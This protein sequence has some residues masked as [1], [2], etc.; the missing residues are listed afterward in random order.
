MGTA[1]TQR[2]LVMILDDDFG[3]RSSLS[4]LLEHE[5]FEV[6]AESDGAHGLDLLCSLADVSKVLPAAI[7]LDL[8]MPNLD[9][10]GFLALRRARR[11]DLDQVP[12]IAISA[13]G[14]PGLGSR[15]VTAFLPKPL[16]VSLLLATLARHRSADRSVN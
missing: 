6:V 1:L 13:I 12:V 4:E 10:Q 7:I 9:G 3:I 14:D 8:V 2:N 5:G 15:S 11:S 16:D